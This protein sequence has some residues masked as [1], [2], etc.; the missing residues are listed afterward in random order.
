MN[1]IPFP[2]QIYFA[3]WVLAVVASLVWLV[4][5]QKTCSLLGTAYRSFLFEGWKLFTFAVATALVTLSAPYSGDPTWDYFDSLLI[6]ALTFLL[7]PWAV[8]VVYRGLVSRRFDAA[9]AVA[10]CLFFVPCWVYDLYI[11]LRDGI[12][13]STWASNLVLSGGLILIA[14]MFWNLC[15]IEGRG[16]SFAFRLEEW[17]DVVA[18]PFKKVFWPCFFLSLPVIAAIGWFVVTFL[19]AG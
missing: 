6:S 9:F 15:L 18:T 12:Y 5:H 11:L 10:C 1:R 7:S 2:L 19:M 14:G 13:P 4:R 8:G 17:P 3:V 16:V